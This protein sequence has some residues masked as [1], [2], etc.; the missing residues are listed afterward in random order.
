M[1]N[2][3]EKIL[4]Y[5]SD[6]MSEEEKQMFIASLERDEQLKKE[7]E[8]IL[9]SLEKIKEPIEA[10]ENYFNNLS[11]NFR[12]KREKKKRRFF[13]EVGLSLATATAV[14]FFLLSP[15]AN[16]QV[17]NNTA[18]EFSAQQIAQ[19]DFIADADQFDS[20]DDL[21]QHFSLEEY[22]QSLSS[23]IPADEVE[24]YLDLEFADLP[25]ELIIENL[26]ISDEDF[27]EI[28]NHLQNEKLL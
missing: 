19:N 14:I 20:Y 4:K 1:K 26:Q 3:K 18:F 17:N 22:L 27:E 24:D 15:S 11:V 25:A 5:L 8:T 12:N 2:N 10:D 23:N 7:Y 16:K 28:Y 6:L 9:S 21:A 13:T